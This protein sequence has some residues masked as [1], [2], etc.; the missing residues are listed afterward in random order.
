[1]KLPPQD[2]FRI[3]LSAPDLLWQVPERH[4]VMLQATIIS[5]TLRITVSTHLKIPL[6]TRT[7]NPSV[8]EVRCKSQHFQ[9]HAI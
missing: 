7:A 6:Q 4:P 1:M 3:Q 8:C 9:R 2:P 5:S